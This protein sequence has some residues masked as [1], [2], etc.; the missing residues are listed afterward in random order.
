MGGHDYYVSAIAD[1]TETVWG[2]VVTSRASNFRPRFTLPTYKYFF[3]SGQLMKTTF[4]ALN[5]T[6]DQITPDQISSTVGAHNFSYY[7]SYWGGNPGFYQTFIFASNQAGA[8]ASPPMSV[9]VNG[10]TGS[11]SYGPGGRTENRD[12][13]SKR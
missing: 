2:F 6:R 8:L 11:F 10:I 7:E 4:A 5:Q 1:L 9:K 12:W 13:A 3:L